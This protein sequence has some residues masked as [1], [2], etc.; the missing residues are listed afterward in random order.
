MDFHGFSRTLSL[1][2]FWIAMIF[3]SNRLLCRLPTTAFRP[4]ESL[5][6]VFTRQS[7]KRYQLISHHG[8]LTINSYCIT[9]NHTKHQNSATH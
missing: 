7:W 9:L 4:Q 1:G 8:W 3:C 5:G 2:P 6:D